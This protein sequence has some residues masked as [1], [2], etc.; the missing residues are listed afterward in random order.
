ML[1]ITEIYQ[2]LQG[3]SSY[4]GLPC[5]FVRLT[6]CNLRCSYCDT[7]YAF[8]GGEKKS[9]EE[10]LEEVKAYDCNLVEIT[11]GEPLLQK[12]CFILVEELCHRG[13][14]VLI[15]TGGSLP[16]QDLHDWVVVILDIKCPSSGESGTFLMNNLKH[17]KYQDEVK[18]VMADRMDY[19]WAVNAMN[20]FKINVP[21]LFSP[22]YGVLEP[23]DLAKWILDDGLKVRLQV[24]LH[25]YIWD[26]N[27]KGV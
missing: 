18:F 3:E 8:H 13:Y 15:E 20:E 12:E 1:T 9:V 2:S 23:K 6:G 5:V 17:L 14:T 25:K 26:E 4:V 24:Q 22:V 10:I 16:I 19:E 7:E 27:A 11:G 21:I